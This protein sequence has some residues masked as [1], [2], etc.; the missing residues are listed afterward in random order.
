MPA[1]EKDRRTLQRLRNVLPHRTDSQATREATERYCYLIE[2]L[3]D[4][5]DEILAVAMY[6]KHEAVSKDQT[7]SE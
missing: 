2:H 6:W 7:E 3:D 5:A 4:G 1:A